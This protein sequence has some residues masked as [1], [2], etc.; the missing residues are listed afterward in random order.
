MVNFGFLLSYGF[1]VVLNWYYLAFL[2]D[3]VPILFAVAMYFNKESPSYLLMKGREAEAR[4]SLQYF[5]GDVI[6]GAVV[7]RT[8]GSISEVTM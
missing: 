5:R 6:V 4:D 8:P 1:G 7:L 3:A 2:C